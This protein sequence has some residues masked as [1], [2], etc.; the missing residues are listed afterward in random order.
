MKFQNEQLALH[1]RERFC[2]IGLFTD[3]PGG[4]ILNIVVI[5]KNARLLDRYFKLSDCKSSFDT[6][7]RSTLVHAARLPH[8]KPRQLV[9]HA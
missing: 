4:H 8:I 3:K 7:G 2:E 5:G 1:F 6:G 9:Q